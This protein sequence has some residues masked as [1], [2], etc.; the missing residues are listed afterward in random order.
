MGRCK[1]T[2]AHHAKTLQTFPGSPAVLLITELVE[3]APASASFAPNASQSGP[4]G[5]PSSEM[6]EGHRTVHSGASQKSTA[7][8]HL[9][10]PLTSQSIQSIMAL[11]QRTSLNALVDCLL[12]V[13]DL[14]YATVNSLK[15]SRRHYA[16]SAVFIHR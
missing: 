3:R 12:N 5:S 2:C 1:L 7:N 8:E 11:V 14:A 16:M 4:V 9:S 13:D 15:Y 6:H 10:F